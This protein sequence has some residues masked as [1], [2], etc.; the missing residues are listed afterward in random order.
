MQEK[1]GKMADFLMKVN[2]H[3]G[4]VVMPKPLRKTCGDRYIL[5]DN[6]FTGVVYLEG[7]S[8]E[9]VLQ[10]LDTLKRHF[11]QLAAMTKQESKK[12]TLKGGLGARPVVCPSSTSQL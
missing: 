3:N 4:Q 9:V 1:A 10:S 7:T 12:G 6:A 2:K 11:V 8:P 5:T